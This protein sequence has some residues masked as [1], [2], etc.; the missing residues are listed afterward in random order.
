MGRIRNPF[1]NL[2]D[3]V[4]SAHSILLPTA[5]LQERLILLHVSS[6]MKSTELLKW[7]SGR[8]KIHPRVFTDFNPQMVDCEILCICVI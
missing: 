8:S 2:S 3:L 4:S 7:K 6:T 5:K 1:S